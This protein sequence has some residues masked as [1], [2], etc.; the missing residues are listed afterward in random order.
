VTRR[1]SRLFNYDLLGEMQFWRHY[2]SDSSPRM[3]LRFSDTSALVIST[4]MLEGSIVW[5]G[6]PA[7]YAMPFSNVHFVD[8]L[9][10]WAEASP[11]EGFWEEADDDLSA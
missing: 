1:K 8:D 2:L 3:T 9:F 4:S 10:S 5:P 6:I 7:E 11:Q